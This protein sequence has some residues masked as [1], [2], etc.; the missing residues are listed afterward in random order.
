MHDRSDL[1][2]YIVEE[3]LM[4][5]SIARVMGTRFEMLAI[6]PVRDRAYALWERV[7]DLLYD[8]DSVFNRFDSSSEVY[9][10]NARTLQEGI[11]VSPALLESIMLCKDYHQKTEGLFDVTL[12]NFAKLDVKDG[13]LSFRDASIRLDFGGFAKGYALRKIKEVLLSENIAD[14]FVDFGRSSIF[15]AGHHPYGDCW[16]IEFPDPYTGRALNVFDLCDMSLSTSGNT[17][18]YSG[19]VVNP[20]TGTRV[21][22]PVASTVLCPDPLDAEVLSTVWMIASEAQRDR[23]KGV[24]EIV[25]EN[26]YELK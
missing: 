4:H 22:G 15:A 5:G 11:P 25:D 1:F 19:H 9:R 18:T 16:K 7:R 20:K 3:N 10:L 21:V 12:Q 17:G 14:A 2:E 13:K 24:F 6:S 8:L 23:I 26:L